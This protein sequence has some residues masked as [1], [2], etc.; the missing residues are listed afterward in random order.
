MATNA[1][2]RESH[3]TSERSSL[4]LYPHKEEDRT[5]LFNQGSPVSHIRIGSRPNSLVTSRGFN[6]SPAI[7]SSREYVCSFIAI[8]FTV[9]IRAARS[10]LA[11]ETPGRT[12]AFQRALSL[13]WGLKG[14]E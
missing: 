12:P 8:P 6:V 1:F 13:I 4:P 14:R 9:L 11:G 3:S 2:S 5:L 7:L 10:N